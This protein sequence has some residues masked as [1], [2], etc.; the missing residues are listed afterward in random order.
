[1]FRR[2]V[3]FA[4][5]YKS[6]LKIR[7]S[8]WE[9]VESYQDTYIETWKLTQLCSMENDFLSGPITS[10]W[11][12]F[13]FTWFQFIN[14]NNDINFLLSRKSL[15]MLIF[16]FQENPYEQFLIRQLKNTVENSK[17]ILICHR[18]PCSSIRLRE[19]RIDLHLLN[20]RLHI[21]NNTHM[22]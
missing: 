14:V 11:L 21:L 4:A 10:I 6:F 9:N 1:M 13:S 12:C 20:M 5:M 19:V 18:Q 3:E 16:F 22:R 2:S 8:F 7:L 17:T 15:M